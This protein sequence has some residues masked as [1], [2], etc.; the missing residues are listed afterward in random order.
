MGLFSIHPNLCINTS[1]YEELHEKPIQHFH[2]LIFFLFSSGEERTLF[3][4]K[5]EKK[6]KN[7]V[8]SLIKAK[9]TLI[10]RK[11]KLSNRRINIIEIIEVPAPNL[12]LEITKTL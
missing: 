9:K 1:P 8:R 5:G 10:K 12:I 2:N 11:T 4:G 7:L 3:K 6:K